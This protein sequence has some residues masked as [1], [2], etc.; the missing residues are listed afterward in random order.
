MQVDSNFFPYLASFDIDALD[1]QEG[2]AYGTWADFRLAFV[3]QGWDAFAQANGG[4]LSG[5]VLG[6]SLLSA[7][8]EPLQSFYQRQF[9]CILREG[10]PWEHTY[11]CS[12]PEQQRYFHMLVFPLAEN[13]GL[14]FVHSQ[15]HGQSHPGPVCE[16]SAELYLDAHGLIRQCAHCRR[17]RRASVSNNWDWVPDLVRKPDLRTSHGLCSACYGFYYSPERLLDDNF[18]KP[19]ST[20]EGL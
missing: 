10:R 9:E 7:I 4:D 19:F 11:E 8:R 20:V 18:P 2:T 14:L 13:R 17:V 3:N 6:T 15:V 1:N 5:D 16:F 12:S